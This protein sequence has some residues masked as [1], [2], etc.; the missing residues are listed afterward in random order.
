MAQLVTV[1]PRIV[2]RSAVTYAGIRERLNRNELGDVVPRLLGELSDVLRRQHIAPAGPPLV[3]YLMV[4]YNTS[5]VEIEVGFPVT[6]SVL[7]PDGR[8]QLG[9]I[10][11]GRYATAMHHGAYASLIDTTAA[12]FEWGKRTHRT[13]DVTE[14]SKITRWG[15]RVE[16][17]E[18]G[19]PAEQDPANWRTEIAIRL[20]EPIP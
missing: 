2:T 6:V 17:Y 8:V 9:T 5:D 15:A 7:P 4:D 3:R 11:A 14:H 13:W 12:L 16:C 18:L 19:P 20:A 1:E 10:P